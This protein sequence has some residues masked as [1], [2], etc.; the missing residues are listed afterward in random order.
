MERAESARAPRLV[1][2]CEEFLANNRE[3]ASMLREGI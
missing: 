3:L 2:Y 1:A